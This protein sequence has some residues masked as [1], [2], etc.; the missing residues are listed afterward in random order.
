[1]WLLQIDKVAHE[2]NKRGNDDDDDGSLNFLMR[3]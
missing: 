2:Q 3:K 1:M